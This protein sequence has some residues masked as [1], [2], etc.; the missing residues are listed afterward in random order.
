MNWGV[1]LAPSTGRVWPVVGGERAVPFTRPDGG[2][3]GNAA[4]RFHASRD[5]R[6]HAAIDLPAAPGQSI[7]AME[8]G[9]V[10]GQVPGFVRLGAVVVAH[11]QVVAVYAE[12][13][14]DSLAR[15]GLAPGS[16]VA[17]GQPI[18]VGALNDSGRSMLHLELWRP[19]F[20]PKGFVP[21]F[22]TNPPPPGLLDPTAY[23][24]ALRD[25]PA[26]APSG[27]TSGASLAPL[28]GIALIGYFAYRWLGRS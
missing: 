13:A 21:W 18:G 7:V 20:A 19:G 6:F 25:G 11:P 10:V 5:G 12:I 23:L 14:L 28:A 8:P 15:S 24:L 3:Q 22:T 2:V 9:V 27:G 4:T 26:I 17:A 16:K 1:P